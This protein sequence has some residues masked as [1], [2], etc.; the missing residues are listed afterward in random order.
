MLAWTDKKPSAVVNI[1]ISLHLWLL[2]LDKRFPCEPVVLLWS[3]LE[4]PA[5][6]WCTEFYGACR[7][8]G[9]RWTNNA[10][11]LVFWVQPLWWMK[12]FDFWV[13]VWPVELEQST[14][15]ILA[16]VEVSSFRNNLTSIWVW[17]WET[18]SVGLTCLD[19][20]W[21]PITPWLTEMGRGAVEEEEKEA[22]FGCK[23]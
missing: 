23:N 2:L 21:N 18:V 10:A 16:Q 11:V 4:A 19:A 8:L 6:R 13:R 7:I 22:N 1:S 9:S 15:P 5:A 12:L 17:V 3:D 14:L 20:F